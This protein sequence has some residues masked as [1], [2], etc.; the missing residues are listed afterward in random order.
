MT[1]S[2]LG[3]G[4]RR[5]E[6]EVNL[7]MLGY[8]LLF[9]SVFFAGLPALIA[10]M[11]AYSQVKEAPTRALR[12]HFAG[13]IR[14]FWVGFALTLVAASCA[15]A[16]LVAGL[17][18]VIGAASVDGFDRSGLNIQLTTVTIPIGIVALLGGAVVFGFLSSAWLMAASSVGFIR[19]ASEPAIGHSRGR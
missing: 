8:A 14:I 5:V 19:L 15:L 1:T 9:A 13:H 7:A 3:A 12:S 18:E 2:Y 16:G 17:G 11:I 6:S 10:V 4:A